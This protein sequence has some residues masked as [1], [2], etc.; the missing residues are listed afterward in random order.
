MLRRLLLAVVPFIAVACSSDSFV[1]STPQVLPP[2]ASSIVTAATPGGVDGFYFRPPLVA[3][4]PASEGEFDASL[5][6]LLAV[7]ICE[8]NGSACVGPAVRRITAEDSPPRR[9]R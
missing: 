4:K 3:A 8:L 6:D 1:E 5:L 7:E 9:L 2:Q